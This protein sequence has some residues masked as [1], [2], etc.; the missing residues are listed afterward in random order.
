M[1]PVTHVHSV[2]R[3]EVTHH[4]QPCTL[5]VHKLH[6]CL[7]CVNGYEVRP[8]CPVQKGAYPTSKNGRP[9]TEPLQK[10]CTPTACAALPITGCILCVLTEPTPLPYGWLQ[11]MQTKSAAVQCAVR[12]C[13]IMRSCAVFRARTATHSI[14]PICSSSWKAPLRHKTQ[15][16]TAAR[17]HDLCG[18]GSQTTIQTAALFSHCQKHLAANPPAW[19]AR[20][21][22]YDKP[23]QAILSAAKLVWHQQGSKHNCT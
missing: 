7:L 12:C 13:A 11:K 22:H 1:N 5:S 9:C 10:G 14:S 15:T 4:P 18:P 8:A 3:A 17:Q 23:W 6:K 20:P 16:V 19:P 21:W 2:L